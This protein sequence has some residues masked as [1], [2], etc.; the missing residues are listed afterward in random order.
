MLVRHYSADSDFTETLTMALVQQHWK[1]RPPSPDQSL[2]TTRKMYSPGSLKVADV[3]AF[4][5]N[6]VDGGA[7]NS[8]FSTIGR[9]LENLTAP[10]PRSMLQETVTA[11]VLG[12]VP[13]SG[14][15]ASSATHTVRSSGSDNVAATDLD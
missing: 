14:A 7:A 4:P 2:A 10:G 5:V 6:F 3:R 1:P 13:A 8:A 9:G 11:G 15:V 12:R